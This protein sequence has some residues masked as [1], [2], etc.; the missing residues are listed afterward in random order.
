Q[1]ASTVAGRTRL[2]AYRGKELLSAEH[3]LELG[4]PLLL[5]E[6]LDPGVRR[7][8]RGL[9][10]PE[11]AIGERGDLRQ[12]RD[13]HHLGMLGETPEQSPHRVGGLA[14]DSGVDLLEHER[15]PPGDGRNCERR[16]PEP[17][18]PRRR[19]DRPKR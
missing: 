16:P 15:L 19:P 8:A 4:L 1:T 18:P 7:V 17:P 13:R 14:A 10:D 12:V 11:M 2:A 9:L 5:A 3:P 6:L